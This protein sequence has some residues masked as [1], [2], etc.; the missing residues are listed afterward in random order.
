MINQKSIT[1]KSVLERIG[2]AGNVPFERFKNSTAIILIVFFL[3]FGT[4]S[5]YMLLNSAA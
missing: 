2:V 1:M 4:A 5:L 3:A